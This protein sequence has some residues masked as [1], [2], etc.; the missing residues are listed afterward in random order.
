MDPLINITIFSLIG[1]CAII[2]GIGLRRS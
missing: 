1:L 2:V